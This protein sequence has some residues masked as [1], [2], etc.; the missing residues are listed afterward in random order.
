[1][2]GAGNASKR[3]Q[4]VLFW[5]HIALLGF[6]SPGH[7]AHPAIYISVSWDTLSKKRSNKGMPQGLKGAV[8]CVKIATGR[9]RDSH[10]SSTAA[11]N[12]KRFEC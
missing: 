8:H 10:A 6:I 9:A 12:V 11:K 4:D 2:A 7:E 3:Q 1:M 5:G